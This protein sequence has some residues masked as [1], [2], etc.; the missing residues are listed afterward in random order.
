MNACSTDTALRDINALIACGVLVRG[1]SGGRST[2]YR[3]VN[4]VIGNG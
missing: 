3:L 1:P 2:E 4:E